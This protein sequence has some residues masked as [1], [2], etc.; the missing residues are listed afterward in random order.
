[1]K[2]YV[3]WIGMILGLLL[4]SSCA[5][6]MGAPKPPQARTCEQFRSW[7]LESK[8][9]ILKLNDDGTIDRFCEGDLGYPKD[10]IGVTI[11]RMNCERDYQDYLVRQCKQWRK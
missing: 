8:P 3:N 10:I 4:I 2:S 1:M 9:C 5:H 7:E 11:Q 6:G